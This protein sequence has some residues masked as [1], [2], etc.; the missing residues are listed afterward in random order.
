MGLSLQMCFLGLRA[1]LWRSDVVENRTRDDKH[2]ST[3]GSAVVVF[4]L[5][6]TGRVLMFHAKA[7]YMAQM[8]F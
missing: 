6:P 5:L 2:G 7:C 3:P 1:N 4:S 8:T